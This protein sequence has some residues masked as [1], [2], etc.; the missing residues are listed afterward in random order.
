MSLLVFPHVPLKAFPAHSKGGSFGAVPLCCPANTEQS[1]P[2]CLKVPCFHYWSLQH[3]YSVIPP[4]FLWS[5]WCSEPR[6]LQQVP[7]ALQQCWLGLGSRIQPLECGRAW[8]TLCAC[9]GG[10]GSSGACQ[11]H[12]GSQGTLSPPAPLGAEAGGAEGAGFGDQDSAWHSPTPTK[13]LCP[14]GSPQ[15][16][17]CSRGSLQGPTGE[18]E[19]CCGCSQSSALSSCPRGLFVPGREAAE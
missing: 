8:Q 4:L 14:H 13:P 6:R 12:P 7:Q 11:S 2:F 10:E 19:S 5:P 1:S 16:C 9:V 3:S 17:H 15:T 18:A